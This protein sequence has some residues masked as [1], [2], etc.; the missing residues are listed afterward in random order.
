MHI[1]N[2][3]FA[4]YGV[5]IVLPA[6]SIYT[7]SLRNVIVRARQSGLLQKIVRDVEWDVQRSPSGKLLSVSY[8]ACLDRIPRATLTR[9][10]GPFKVTRG[11]KITRNTVEER[12]LTT[13]DTQGMFLILGAGTLIGFFV[14]FAECC[15]HRVSKRRDLRASV[16]DEDDWP[17]P[18]CERN[19]YYRMRTNPGDAVRPRYSAASI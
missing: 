7:E 12:Q 3:C 10:F 19:Y 6:Q 8:R 4:N 14:L 1:S 15:V 16:E 5:T 17:E 11:Q 2:E 9:P 13:D 18:L